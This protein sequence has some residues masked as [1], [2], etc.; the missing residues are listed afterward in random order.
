MGNTLNTFNL[1]FAHCHKYND[2]QEPLTN[3]V[4]QQG[5]SMTENALYRP[6]QEDVITISCYQV[7]FLR[8]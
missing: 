5:P 4:T 1:V 7:L 3:F 6:A 2:P 8:W